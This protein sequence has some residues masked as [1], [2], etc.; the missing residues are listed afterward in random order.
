MRNLTVDS[1]WW[2]N[3]A[4]ADVIEKRDDIMRQS[5]SEALDELSKAQ[6]KEPAAWQWGALH[7]ATFRNQTLGESGI[8]LIEKLF[9]R[10]PFAVNGGEALVNANR[11]DRV[12]RFRG[13]LAAFHA[14]DCGFE[15]PERFAQRTHNR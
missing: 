15:R 8:G 11:L 12:R 3:A 14:H 13:R 10:G 5:F 7:T 4:T 2:D 9:N 6:G 1:G